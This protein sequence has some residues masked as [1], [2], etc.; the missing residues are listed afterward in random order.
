MK[1]F[2]GSPAICSHPGYNAHAQNPPIFKTARNHTFRARAKFTADLCE[3]I[4]TRVESCRSTISLF[5]RMQ[6]W[7][8]TPIT[9]ARKDRFLPTHGGLNQRNCG[10]EAFMCRCT[11]ARKTARIWRIT[12][13][14]AYYCKT[15]NT[16]EN[17]TV[18]NVKFLLSV[19]WQEHL[20]LEHHSSNETL[21][22]ESYLQLHCAFGNN[23]YQNTHQL[24]PQNHLLIHVYSVYL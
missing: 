19:G 14:H 24:A 1:G 8:Q 9:C 16:A 23:R 5:S 10:N 2:V 15:P 20:S 17:F 3:S 13:V 11:A 18:L 21:R 7:Y 22:H 4:N 12:A 6:S